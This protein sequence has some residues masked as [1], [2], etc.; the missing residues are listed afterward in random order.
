MHGLNEVPLEWE[1]CD[2]DIM[3]GVQHIINMP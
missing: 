3:F 1:T 2:I